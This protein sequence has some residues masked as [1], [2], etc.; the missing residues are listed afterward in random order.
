MARGYDLSISGI[1]NNLSVITDFAEYDIRINPND[2]IELFLPKADAAGNLLLREK[3]PTP[4]GTSSPR[5]RQFHSHGYVNEM[6]DA[7]DCALNED[8][9]PQSGP[10]MAWDTMAVLMAGYESNDMGGA[11][12]DIGEFVNGREFRANEMPTPESFGRVFQ[13]A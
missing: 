7:V 8:R 3:L 10:L 9:Y 11:F 1:R 12:V 4:V 2:E 5:P 6:E 13:R